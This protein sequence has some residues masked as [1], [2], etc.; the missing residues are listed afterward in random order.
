VVEKEQGVFCHCH[1]TFHAG[2][3]TA[4]EVMARVVTARGGGNH[5]GG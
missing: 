1:T 3:S 5:M 4:H 2:E